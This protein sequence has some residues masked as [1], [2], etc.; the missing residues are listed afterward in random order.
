MAER[1]LTPEE[2]F[3]RWHV[4]IFTHL[5]KTSEIKDGNGAI[6]ALTAALP[7]YERWLEAEAS[8]TNPKKSRAAVLVGDLGIATEDDA[9]KFWNVFRDGLCHTGS[10]FS[11]SGKSRS[12]GWTLPK[13]GLSADYPDKPLFKKAKTGEDAIFINP[14]GLIRHILKKYENNVSLMQGVD[15]P[16]LELTIDE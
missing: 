1:K 2:R 8:K 4:D 7:L 14:W 10:F 12:E 6:V 15:A 3:K 13:I 5:E 16:M 9:Q 11:E